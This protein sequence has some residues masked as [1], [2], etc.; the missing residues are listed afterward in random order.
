MILA[1]KGYNSI[2]TK[3]KNK[4]IRAE[5]TGANQGITRI[6]IHIENGH[7]LG[8]S[9]DFAIR[10]WSLEDQRQRVGK[11]KIGMPPNSNFS[12]HSPAIPTK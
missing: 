7:I 5:F 1:Q 4:F 6:D 3:K 10:V 8:A 9:N 2:K 12:L 11:I